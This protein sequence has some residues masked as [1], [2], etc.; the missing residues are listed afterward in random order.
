MD[1]RHD[2][3]R[4]VSVINEIDADLVGLQEVVLEPNGGD[5]ICLESLSSATG[6]EVISGPTFAC[7]NGHFGNVVL[8]RGKVLHS[9]RLDLSVGSREP[10]CA[11]GVTLEY[12]GVPVRVI[13]THLG[14]RSFERKR[15]IQTLLEYVADGKDEFL[16]IMGDFNLWCPASRSL[17]KMVARFGKAPVL[18]TYP[19]LMP[20]FQLDRIWVQPK[21][22]L[23]QLQ[24]HNT[25]RSRV[26]SDH[27]PIKG[28]IQWNGR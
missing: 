5:G 9:D 28:L 6:L 2:P 1:R 25:R 3:Q 19:T 12:S 15:Q 21:E 27:L 7:G 22:V 14:L 10:R 23:H 20:L 24:V 13:V 4:V 11:I 18:R 26:A 17:R 8:A 16:I